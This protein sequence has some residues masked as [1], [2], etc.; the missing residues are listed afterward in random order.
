MPN[1][2]M[3]LCGSGNTLDRAS[4][5]GEALGFV[6]L[7]IPQV[8]TETEELLR[9]THPI[10]AVYDG[11]DPRGI[12][13]CTLIRRTPSLDDVQILA[14]VDDPWGQAPRRAF[15]LGADDFVPEQSLPQLA[16][17]LDA[18][19]LESPPV[20]ASY[21]GKIILAAES[22]D[23]RIA[24]G[25]QLRRT[26]LELQ[27]AVDH[28]FPATA[29]LKLVVAHSALPPDGVA[30]GLRKFR[31]ASGAGTPWVVFGSRGELE[32]VQQQIDGEGN[33]AYFDTG[34]DASQIVSVANALFSKEVLS[35]RKTARHAYESPVRWLT[36]E[37]SAEPRWGYLYNINRDGL[38][39]RTLS[40]PAPGTNVSLEFSPPFG[41]GRVVVDCAVVWR[42]P[43]CSRRGQPPGFGVRFA[44]QLAIADAA[45]LEAGYQELNRAAQAQRLDL[46][47]TAFAPSQQCAV[48]A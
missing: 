12:E 30:K 3:V 32:P 33:L 43:F 2:T 41:R 14:I 47:S 28:S 4:Q 19:Q 5:I 31:K 18:L 9:N 42:Q 10:C 26:G 25:R 44:A 17:T 1:K 22:R 36:S 34:T 16:A 21:T 6:R 7:S 20:G 13:V 27:F 46:T 39:V 23:Q 48:S 45:A 40:P 37:D 15:T 29:D 11:A 35:Q 8:S 24:L 38:Y